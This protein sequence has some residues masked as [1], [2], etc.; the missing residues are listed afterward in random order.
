MTIAKLR[1]ARRLWARVAEVAGDG[2]TPVPRLLH[3][4]SS[5]PMMTS[6]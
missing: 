4:V 2:S 6:A 3:A 5:A 1:A